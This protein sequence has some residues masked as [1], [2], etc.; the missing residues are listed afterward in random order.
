LVVSRAR[1]IQRFLSQPFQV[2]EVFTGH[3]GKF[4]SLEQ[5]IDGFES[6]LKGK[7]IQGVFYLIYLQASW[8][9]FLKSHSTCRETFRTCTRRLRSWLNFKRP[10]SCELPSIKLG[11]NCS[12]FT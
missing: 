2:A 1:K 9:T 7:Q 5:T 10:I 8:I 3:Q 11:I 6:I 12:V 4:V